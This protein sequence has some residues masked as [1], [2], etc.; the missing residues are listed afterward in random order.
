MDDTG[1]GEMEEEEEEEEEELEEKEVSALDLAEVDL[2]DRRLPQDPPRFIMENVGQKRRFRAGE[3]HANGRG[4]P[5]EKRDENVNVDSSTKR[6]FSRSR[7]KNKPN[8]RAC[9]TR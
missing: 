1:T 5:Y 3:R 4:R 6:I 9:A 2:A 8:F 7:A